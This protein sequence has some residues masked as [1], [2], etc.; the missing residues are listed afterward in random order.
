MFFV[1][2]RELPF[3]QA[4]TRETLPELLELPLAMNGGRAV[5][6]ETPLGEAGP[7][8]KACHGW[9]AVSHNKTWALSGF[10]RSHSDNPGEACGSGSGE[11]KLL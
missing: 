1:H 7:L 3:T 9:L 2:Q 11:V 6:T 10:R 8:G 4:K 5:N